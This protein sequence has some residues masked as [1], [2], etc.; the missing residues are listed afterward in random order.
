MLTFNYGSTC[1]SNEIVLTKFISVCR[2][3]W[4]LIWGA[5][6]FYKSKT[7]I[8]KRGGNSAIWPKWSCQQSIIVL[9]TPPSSMARAD[10]PPI[11]LHLIFEI[12]S[13]PIV[14]IDFLSILNWI[15]AGYTDSKMITRKSR[16]LSL[17]WTQSTQKV[18]K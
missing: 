15:F 6:S 9:F 7:K 2:M 14:E 1:F 3:V 10:S 16:W 8:V 5:S 17:S 13:S 4:D 12:C 18:G 11:Y